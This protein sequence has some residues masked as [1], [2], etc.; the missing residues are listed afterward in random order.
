MS[1]S[2][3]ASQGPAAAENA[4]HEREV[5][6]TQPN[7]VS[8]ED[9]LVDR[10]LD[11]LGQLGLVQPQQSQPGEPEP[12]QEEEDN[13]WDGPDWDWQPPGRSSGWQQSWNWYGHGWH[14]PSW[15]NDGEKP[16]R[17]YISHLDFPKFDGKREEYSN[18]QYAVVSLK[19]QCAPRDYKYLAPKLRQG[20]PDP[21]Q[22]PPQLSLT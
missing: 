5:P 17:P 1:S 2:A 13:E 10:L 8:E 21:T 18:Y 16:D 3:Q 4:A 12:Q 19:S 9:R 7:G 15:K 11:R 22:I 20:E 14:A 6:D